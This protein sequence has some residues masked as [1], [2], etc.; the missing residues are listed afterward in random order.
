RP[1]KEIFAKKAANTISTIAL[2]NNASSNLTTPATITLNSTL[3]YNGR[4][5]IAS[6]SISNINF[7]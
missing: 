2:T 4:I 7:Y 1:K 3:L 5:F 6:N